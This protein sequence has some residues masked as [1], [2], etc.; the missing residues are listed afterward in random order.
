MVDR[1]I[2][3]QSSIKGS[4]N[5]RFKYFTESL[6]NDMLGE[7][8]IVGIMATSLAE[9]QF[10]V[11]YQPQYNHSTGMLIGAEALVR[12]NHPERGMISPGTFIP[13]FEKNGF[14]TN[15]DLYVF[16]EVCIFIR[17]C[18]DKNLPVV[19]ISSNFSRYDIFQ[20]DFVE[21]LEEIRLKYEV[22][23]KNIRVELTE[24]AVLGGTQHTNEVISKLHK[25]GYIVEMDD[26]GS[27]YSSLNVLKDIELDIIKL[28]MKFLAKE[29]E[30]NKGGTIISSIVKMVE[31]AC[32]S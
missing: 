26:F 30:S 2:L 28:D 10:V 13:I 7:Q 8:E 25:C 22:P 19:P 5:K 3:A 17:K 29:S 6:R 27:G 32:N 12:W 4:Y 24:S 9:K 31:Y 20:P 16:E 11:Y 1:A 21:K 15:L 18:M 23:V 14:I